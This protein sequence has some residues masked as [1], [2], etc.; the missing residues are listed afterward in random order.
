VTRGDLD[1][2]T[3]R[4]RGLDTCSV[5]DALDR[6]GVGGVVLGLH[7]LSVPLRFGGPAVTVKL[8]PAV[9]AR[10]GDRHL[11][12][13][14]IE[15]AEPGS[16]IV[17]DHGGREAV[18]G[19]GGLLSLGAVQRGVAGVVV[20]GAVRD[21][22]EARTFGLPIT[23]RVAV[24]V[25][26]R[27]RIVEVSTGDPVCLAGVDVAPGD[28]V[29]SDGSGVVVVPQGRADEVLEAAEAIAQREAQIAEQIRAGRPIT[30]ALGHGYET[31]VERTGRG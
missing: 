28:L 14:A 13:A 15:A 12:T 19:W 4:L 24:P 11:G 17:V 1:G 9:D 2:A 5:S 10:P 29:L 31:L 20:D 18:A 23:A 27:G 16:V 7:Q 26:A 3:R 8:G 25:T 21:V 30:E 6:L 22:D